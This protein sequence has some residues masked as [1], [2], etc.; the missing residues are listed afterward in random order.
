MVQIG[1]V[2]YINFGPEQGKL[3]VIVDVLDLK[4]AIV[5]CQPTGVARQQMPF[6]RLSLTEFV[7]PVARNAK[8]SKVAKAFHAEK[9]AEKWQETTDGKS[10]AAKLRRANLTDFER[11]QVLV[12][13]K[14][15]SLLVKQEVKKLAPKK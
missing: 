2:C 8:S 3:C 9:I 12:A 6:T 13:K 14:Q 7:I 5:D 11:F 10:I 15:K 4:R 1:R